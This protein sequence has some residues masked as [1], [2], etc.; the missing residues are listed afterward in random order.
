M[1][2]FKQRPTY[3]SVH[4]LRDGTIWFAE[5]TRKPR[6]TRHFTPEIDGDGIHNWFLDEEE[7][8]RLTDWGK[9]LRHGAVVNRLNV[10]RAIR[11]QVEPK[12][13]ELLNLVRELSERV[14]RLEELLGAN[15]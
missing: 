3:Y 8:T 9:G 1:S 11:E 6:T 14:S 5:Q 4:A 2:K 7:P 12:L 15:G 10:K 13:D